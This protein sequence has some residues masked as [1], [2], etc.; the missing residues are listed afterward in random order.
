[1]NNKTET[2]NE[3]AVEIKNRKSLESTFLVDDFL[4][5]ISF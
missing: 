3:I 4:E 1:M 5:V 2:N